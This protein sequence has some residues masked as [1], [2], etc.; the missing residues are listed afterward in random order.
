M[1]QLI[2]QLK[3]I[4]GTNFGLY[5][6]S[7]NYHWN[8]EGNNFPQYHLFLN[9]FYNEVFLQNDLIAEHIRYLDAYAPGSFSRFME[10]SAVEDSTTV[11]DPLTMMI[12]LKNDNDKYI[13]QLRAGIIL[14]EQSDEPAVSNFLQ[15]LLGAQQKKAWMLSSIIK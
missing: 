7:H 13:V 6:K 11:P 1:E 2:E 5:L 4:L 10:L 8:V 12:T 15:E 3:V 9:T 14:A